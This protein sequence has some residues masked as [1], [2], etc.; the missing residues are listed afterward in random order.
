MVN[1]GAFDRLLR[2]IL[3]VVFLMFGW[4]M[5]GGAFGTVLVVLSGIMLLTAAIGMCPIYA[6]LGLDTLDHSEEN[7]E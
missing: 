5:V 4:G 6:A 1:E 3:G 2:L 7:A